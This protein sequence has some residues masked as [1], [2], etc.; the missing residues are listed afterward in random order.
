MALDAARVGGLPRQPLARVFG[1]LRRVPRTAWAC[2][3]VA[4]LSAACW[5]LVT[6]PFQAPD[7]PSHFAYVQYL[8]ET[9]SLP[10][11]SS[12]KFSEEEEAVL[13]GLRLV[14]VRWH[15]EVR[16]IYP[17]GAR[18]ELQSAL[19]APLARVGPSSAGVATSEPPL[20][21]ALE[22]IPYYLGSGGTLLERLAL[23]RLLS[24]L[25]AGLT[26]LFTFLFVREALPGARWAWTVGGLA[27]ALIP[28]LGFTSGIVT[29]DAMLCAVSA[30]TFYCLAR[31]FRRELTRGLAVAIGATLAV[32]FLT[33]VNFVGLAPG[34]VLGLVVLA[35]RG[36]RD[37][38]RGP[39]RRHAFGPMAIAMAIAISPVGV[40]AFYNLLAGKPT[41]G[42]V[43]SAIGL[44]AGRESLLSDFV[45]IWQFYLPRLPGMANY[46]P[47]VST[48][49]ELW[50]D[51]WVG[52][53]GWFDTSF[54]TWADSLALVPAALLALLAMRTLL[55]RRRSFLARRSELLVYIVV[56]LGL[57][58]LL[59][60]DSHLHRA[61]EGAGYI[62]P[63]YLLP[64]LPL[65]A[66]LLALAARGAGRRWGPAVGV[67]IV[68]LF[69][70][71]DIFS[72]L[73]VVARFY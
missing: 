2:A 50:F 27:A 39:R 13:R 23:M 20:Y 26:A 43:S 35:V 54:P 22:A 53:Y 19:A 24:A 59:G 52:L 66:V 14:A 64:L 47:G 42:I 28:V 16:T 67:L 44:T 1:A 32:G 41:L 34:V 58:S 49:R 40:Y 71:Q 72:Q 10:T 36:V 48:T 25:M 29:P 56:S 18:A 17:A 21:Y 3:L 38:P 69:L 15:P 63:R 31:G 46:F 57:M 45:Y 12:A 68:L 5:S 73:Q 11:S 70:A 61:T 8:A 62:Q 33:K 60:Q 6:P 7:E 9:G 65:G 51:R 55:V 37:G 4:T 30:A